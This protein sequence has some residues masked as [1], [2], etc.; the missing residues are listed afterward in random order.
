MCLYNYH[1]KINS[2]E[3]LNNEEYMLLQQIYNSIASNNNK[4]TSELTEMLISMQ[5]S[6][7]KIEQ[8]Q[9]ALNSFK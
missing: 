6:K 7:N 5:S 1:N 3:S 8:L 2:D 9:K 4:K